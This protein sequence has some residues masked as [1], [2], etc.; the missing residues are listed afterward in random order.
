MPKL[1]EVALPSVLAK[2][3]QREH[4]RFKDADADQE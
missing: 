3:A 2:L 4:E 1:L